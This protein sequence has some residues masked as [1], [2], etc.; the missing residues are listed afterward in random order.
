MVYICRIRV[1][2]H[3]RSGG[4]I[5]SHVFPMMMRA[6]AA[7]RAKLA[8]FMVLALLVTGVFGVR[9]API[10]PAQAMH[11]GPRVLA[12]ALHARPARDAFTGSRSGARLTQAG[13]LGQI[14]RRPPRHEEIE[15]HAQAPVWP[16][17]AK[18]AP[19]VA[20]FFFRKIP[21]DEGA[22]ADADGP[23]HPHQAYRS[24]APP[25]LA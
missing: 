16:D 3:H 20:R 24:R 23:T 12:G 18:G 8:A 5:L 14:G 9:P 22:D 17:A 11:H 21:S 13:R 1:I 4:G 2:L 6:H 25:A 19:S 10:E 15:Q 7:L